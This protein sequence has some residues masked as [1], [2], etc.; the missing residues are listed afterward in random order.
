M[1]TCKTRVKPFDVLNKNR[2]ANIISADFFHP[3]GWRMTS[4]TKEKSDPQLTEEPW[5]E[6]KPSS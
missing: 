5:A 1:T 2:M 4:Q 6:K 3:I